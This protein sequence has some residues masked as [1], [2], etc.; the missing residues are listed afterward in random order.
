MQTESQSQSEQELEEEQAGDD[1]QIPEEEPEDQEAPAEDPAPGVSGGD[2]H[3]Y[4]PKALYA[5]VDE[6]VTGANG[7]VNLRSI[8]SIG[9]DSVVVH[10]LETGETVTRTAIGENGWSKVNYN[11]RELYAVTEFLTVY[12]EP[13]QQAEE[14][15]QEEEAENEQEA[16]P[17]DGQKEQNAQQKSGYS[18]QW[19]EDNRKCS[20]WSAGVLQG[21]LTI[22]DGEGTPQTITYYGTYNQGS[23]REQKKYF[24]LSVPQGD[25]PSVINV[26]PGFIAAIKDMGYSGVYLNKQIH[27]W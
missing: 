3:I 26:D 10:P 16:A 25:G 6:V 11:G 18:V 24:N 8:P 13:E 17:E 4:D 12:T 21:T 14:P 9:A 20:I 7:V 1:Q 19:T 23:E 27:N 15:G 2:Y 22:T 5:T